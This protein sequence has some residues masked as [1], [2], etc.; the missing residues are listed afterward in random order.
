MKICRNCKKIFAD[1]FRGLCP[2]CSTILDDSYKIYKKQDLVDEIAKSNR[3]LWGISWRLFIKFFSFISIVGFILGFSILKQINQLNVQ[4]N[5]RIKK[6]FKEPKITATIENVAKDNTKTI[7]KNKI[8]PEV[9]KFRKEILHLHK[10]ADSILKINT[11]QFKSEIDRNKKIINTKLN[12]LDKSLLR[13]N[14]VK[15]KVLNIEKEIK[16]IEKLVQTPVLNLHALEWKE[17]DDKNKLLV[18]FEASR[19]DFVNAFKFKV[20]VINSNEKIL[21]LYTHRKYGG[22]QYGS[23][24]AIIENNYKTAIYSFKPYY[25]AYP[26]IILE[27]S[28]KTDLKI[29]GNYIAKP[30]II[31]KKYY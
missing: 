23:K 19:D 29:E 31:K 8:N 26:V 7:I 5:D 15:K 13:I 4:I 27:L 6:E 1:D 25:A 9:K 21:D 20:T 12:E 24:E 14:N 3:V 10:Q 30:I 16:N 18:Q 2:N 11:L 22:F 17:I 28:D